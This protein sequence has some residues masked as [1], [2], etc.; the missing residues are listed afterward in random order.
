MVHPAPRSSS[1]PAPN[2]ASVAASG[3][4]PG[5]AA[6]AMDQKHG[7]ASSQVPAASSKTKLASPLSP[8][9]TE[10]LCQVRSIHRALLLPT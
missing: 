2:S 6:S 8:G 5:A 9:R 4:A 7:Q 10:Q 1:A 3:G